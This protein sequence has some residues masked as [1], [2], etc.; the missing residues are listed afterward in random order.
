MQY[1]LGLESEN[2]KK[3]QKKKVWTR[4]LAQP[5]QSKNKKKNKKEQSLPIKQFTKSKQ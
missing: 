3:Q 5:K 2:W 1:R 4:A